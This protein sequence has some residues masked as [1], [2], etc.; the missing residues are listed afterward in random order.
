MPP[1]GSLLLL[2][3]LCPHPVA[4]GGSDGSGQGGQAEGRG[5]GHHI[6][7]AGYQAPNLANLLPLNA[8]Q[9]RWH[10]DPA[11]MDRQTAF[12]GTSLWLSPTADPRA[13]L[14][15]QCCAECCL[16]WQCCMGT[17]VTAAPTPWRPGTAEL[18]ALGQ[19]SR[20]LA[21]ITSRWTNLR[22]NSIWM[23]LV[24]Q[25]TFG[26][27]APSSGFWFDDARWEVITENWAVAAAAGHNSS[28]TQLFVRPPF[29]R[30]CPCSCSLFPRAS[31]LTRGAVVWASS[32]PRSTACTTGARP[33]TSKSSATAPSSTTRT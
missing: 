15:Q 17:R 18:A 19:Q 14:S 13:D 16:Q 29:S 32:T 23:P 26:R 31:V 33:P 9:A 12:D 20:A 10:A 2:V 24:S 4:I 7:Y 8:S 28:A 30:C 25:Q 1:S 21:S 5:H 27:A 6:V 11:A 3:L 22:S